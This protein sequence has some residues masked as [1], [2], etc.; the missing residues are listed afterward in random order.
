VSGCVSKCRAVCGFQDGLF[1]WG[2]RYLSRVCEK[3]FSEAV[4]EK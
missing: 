4:F 3:R 1:V 2:S